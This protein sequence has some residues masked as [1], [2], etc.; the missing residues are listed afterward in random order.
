MTDGDDNGD[1]E[2]VPSDPGADGVALV[3]QNE[4]PQAIGQYGRGIGYDGIKRSLAVEFDTYHNTP[5]NDPNGNHVGVQSM[6]R[7]ENS[8]KHAPPANLAFSSNVLPMKADGTVYYAYLTYINKRLSVYL[9]SRPSFQAP[10]LVRDIDID[11]LIGLDSNGR[12]WV[13]VTSATGRSMEQHEIVR[14]EINACPEDSPVSVYEGRPTGRADTA[15]FVIVD[16][17]LLRG[18]AD[19]CVVSVVDLQG[20]VLWSASS[21]ARKVELPAAMLHSGHYFVSVSSAI[22]T[23]TVRWLVVH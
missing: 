13:G 6:G 5:V 15:P 3:I 17:Y 14:W 23:T 1:V 11:S 22:S 9:N 18:D 2:E 19:H 12:A 7:A 8:S 10:V 4:G 16:D 21:S 20:R